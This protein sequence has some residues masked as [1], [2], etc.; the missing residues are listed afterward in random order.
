M[1]C[2]SEGG[3]LSTY[4]IDSGSD[5]LIDQAM[6]TEKSQIE[7]QTLLCGKSVTKRIYKEI[8]FNQIKEN[9][10]LLYS[11]L[12]FAGYLNPTP[13]EL[14]TYKLSI[15]SNQEVKKIYEDRVIQ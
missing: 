14:D 7:L 13:I 9:E 6:L 3:G 8:D 1:H 10:D 5:E 15:P 12:V 4:W 2:L 11:L